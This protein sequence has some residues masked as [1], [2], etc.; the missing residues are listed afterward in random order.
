MAE[1]WLADVRKYAPGADENVVGA[2]VK[3]LGIALQ[4]R[5]SSLVAFSDPVEVGRVRDGYMR[6]KLALTDSDGVLNEALDWVKG[7]MKADRTK[8]R[9]TVYY[10]LAHYFGKLDL[11]GGPAGTSPASLSAGSSPKPDMT[12]LAGLGAAGAAGAAAILNSTPEPKSADLSSGSDQSLSGSPAT[13]TTARLVRP[14]YAAD[15]DDDGGR[16][17]GSI[18]WLAWLLLALL[19]IALFFFLKGCMA[20][21]PATRD[22]AAA[23]ETSAPPVSEA[24]PGTTADDSGAASS[25][26]VGAGV[27]SGTKDGKPLLTVYFASGKSAVSKDLATATAPLKSYLA[28]T[29]G[30]KLAISGYND[31]SG[32]AALNA[33]LSKKRAQAVAAA[34]VSAGIPQGS[35]ELIKPADTTSASVTP[36]QA[37]RVEVT[38]Q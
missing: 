31:P 1:D 5:D 12:T 4:N 19:A 13:N 7:L 35:I 27:I 6:N 16:G 9:V 8:N 17:M 34:L 20:E 29:S 11:F 2:I 37:R 18:R 25:A 26:P 28:S 24:S 15:L 33:A 3:H 38:V 30:A 10:L 32:N 14:S 36:E 23:I 21:K 22:A